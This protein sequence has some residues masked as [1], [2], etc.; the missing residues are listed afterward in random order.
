[1]K[2]PQYLSGRIQSLGSLFNLRIILC[3]VDIEDTEKAILEITKLCMMSDCT[4]ILC[5]SALEA[6]RYIETYKLY[7][8]KSAET[9]QAKVSDDY[10]PK[11]TDI[12]TSIRSMNKTDVI[13]LINNFRTLHNIMSSSLEELSILPGFGE[14]KVKRLADVLHAPFIPSKKAETKKEDKSAPKSK[15]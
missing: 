9:I 12:L 10:M 7:E 8:N 14:K 6:A 1:L 15:R 2:K 5:F 4:L 11:L 3:Q 13:T